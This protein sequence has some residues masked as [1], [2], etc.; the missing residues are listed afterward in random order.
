MRRLLLLGKQPESE[1]AREIVHRALAYTAKLLAETGVAVIVDATA[2]RRAWRELARGLIA[3]FAEVQLVCPRAACHER[4]RAVR[5]HLA[6][7]S[8]APHAAPAVATMPDIVLDYEPSRCPELTLYTDSRDPRWAVEEVLRLADRLPS[9][10][11]P[12]DCER[13]LSP[14]LRVREGAL[15]QGPW[16][17]PGWRRGQIANKER[18]GQERSQ[19]SKQ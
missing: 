15:Q 6:G 3:R 16:L 4:E 12:E 1:Y 14:Q 2:P 19:I 18:H 13:I 10:K 9:I 11:R 17:R 7:H 5:W 8:T